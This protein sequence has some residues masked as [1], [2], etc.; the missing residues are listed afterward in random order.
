MEPFAAAARINE[1]AAAYR[2][3]QVLFTALNEGVFALL[4]EPHSSDEAAASL[5]WDSRG[6]RIFLDA[7]VAQGLVEKEQGLYRNGPLATQCLAPDSP[8]YQGDI[9]RHNEGSYLNYTRIAEVV[10]NGGATPDDSVARSPEQ[11]RAFILG[12]ANISRATAEA[13]VDEVDLSHY[14]RLLDAGGGPGTY[15]SVFLKHHPDMRATLVDRPEVVAIAREQVE[16]EGLTERFTFLPGDILC[17]DMGEGHDLVLVSNIIHSYNPEENRGVFRRCFEVM[18][19]GGM[20]MVNDFFVE[21][22]RTGPRWG[23]MFALHMLVHTPGGDTYTFPEID[24]W[25]RE[26]GFVDGRAVRL[27]ERSRLWLAAKP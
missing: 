9:I 7:L 10:R 27:S 16:K 2:D 11:L 26:A 17:D 12:M 21:E 22:D 25:T 14:R 6:A 5:G 18:A 1:M 19:P 23:L 15:S 20:L 13:I 3:S 8:W 4:R 24:A